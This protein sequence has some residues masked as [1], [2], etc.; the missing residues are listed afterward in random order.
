MGGVPGLRE[1]WLLTRAVVQ[2]MISHDL[3]ILR[4]WDNRPFTCLRSAPA[5]CGYSHVWMAPA[6]QGVCELLATGRLRPCIRRH[7]CGV[8]AARHDEFRVDLV[9]INGPRC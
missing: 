5:I 3:C 2:A 1:V 8:V 4:P 7:W 9:P 6:W